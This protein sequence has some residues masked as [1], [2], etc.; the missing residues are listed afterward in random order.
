[1]SRVLVQVQELQPRD[2]LGRIELTWRESG[3]R[4]REIK[5][6]T[7]NHMHDGVEEFTTTEIVNY[8][9]RQE[10]ERLL[11]IYHPDCLAK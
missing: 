6:L 5:T 8:R 10:R 7:G 3:T 2:G 11:R 4:P 9:D 1:M